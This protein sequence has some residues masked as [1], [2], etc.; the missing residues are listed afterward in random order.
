MRSTS[1]DDAPVGAELLA[2]PDGH[3]VLEVGSPHLDEAVK[4]LL[5][6]G[7][8]VVELAELDQEGAPQVERGDVD[9]GGE[10]VVRR[11]RHVDVGV[12]A[13]DLVA[14]LRRPED[15]QRPVGDH[16]V[17]V[18]VD[19]GAGAPLDGV[20]D[21][22]GVHL[23]GD[24]VVGRLGDGVGQPG[25]DVARIPVGEG[26]G[27][28]HDGH[29]PDERRVDGEAG[30]GEVLGAPQRLDAVVGLGGDLAIAEEVVLDAGG[31]HG[32]GVS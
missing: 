19:G 28:L 22:L 6:G 20:H 9:A 25:V 18:H 17:G 7:E 8:G 21:E 12:R 1:S 30:D 29:G 14:P 5:L 11:L 24:D 23:P 27:L 32:H 2:E 16:L 13:D 15:L 10:C 4:L 3:R 26:G 31:V